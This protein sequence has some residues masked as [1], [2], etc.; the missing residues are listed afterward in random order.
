VFWFILFTL[1]VHAATLDCSTQSVGLPSWIKGLTHPQKSNQLCSINSEKLPW[2]D[3]PTFESARLSTRCAGHWEV[4]NSK[5]KKEKITAGLRVVKLDSKHILY[6]S[7][8]ELREGEISEEAFSGKKDCSESER[9]SKKAFL[10]EAKMSLRFAEEIKANTQ[11]SFNQEIAL[12]KKKLR[13]VEKMSEEEFQKLAASWNQRLPSES[14]SK[15][16]RLAKIGDLISK[17]YNPIQNRGKKLFDETL[18]VPISQEWFNSNPKL[19]SFYQKEWLDSNLDIRIRGGASGE[20]VTKTTDTP[21]EGDSYQEMVGLMKKTNEFISKSNDPELTQ[22]PEAL[23]LKKNFNDSTANAHRFIF[24]HPET[25]HASTEKSPW[26]EY[27]P[28]DQSIGG[29]KTDYLTSVMI[30]ELNVN[31][32]HFFPQDTHSEMT[33]S[34]NLVGCVKKNGVKDLDQSPA[35]IQ[36]VLGLN[37]QISTIYLKMILQ[38]LN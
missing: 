38:S 8:N 2:I 25:W 24:V 28:V 35:N 16:E 36:K 10:E 7:G 31:S 20:G 11:P 26:A 14:L 12:V 3:P 22:S 15:P 23:W 9:P 21:T 29:L 27:I 13:L 34:S 33:T 18:L 19:K 17:A 30:H 5:G 4:K 32:E 1:P 6:Y 37:P